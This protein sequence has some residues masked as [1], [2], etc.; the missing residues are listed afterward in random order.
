MIQSTAKKAKKKMVKA[1]TKGFIPPNS[2]GQ[3]N[4]QPQPVPSGGPMMKGGGKV[5]KSK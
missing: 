1:P 4:Q 5:K 3:G 2:T